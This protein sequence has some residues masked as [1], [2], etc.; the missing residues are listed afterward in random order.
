MKLST[1]SSTS[2]RYQVRI[3][4]VDDV[5]Q[6][7]QDLHLLL[8]LSDELLVVGDTGSGAEAIAKIASLHPDVVLMDLAMPEMD[9][10]ETALQVKNHR[11]ECRVIAFSIHGHPQ[12]RLRARQA[13]MDGFIEKGTPLEEIIKE[14]RRVWDNS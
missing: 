5:S 4:I 11:P 1:P 8:D 12:A 14:I 9:G 2:N 13:G 7:R 6:V 3:M 10:Y